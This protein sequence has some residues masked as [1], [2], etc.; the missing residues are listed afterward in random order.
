MAG[1]MHI[2]QQLVK[3]LKRKLQTASVMHC[4][5]SYVNPYM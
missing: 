3:N 2:T 5:A 4:Q 1:K